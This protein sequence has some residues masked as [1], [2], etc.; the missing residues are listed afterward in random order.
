M[1]GIILQLQG[2]NSE[3]IIAKLKNNLNI[4]ELFI[5]NTDE[6]F[7]LK[8]IRHDGWTIKQI[9]GHL[10]DTQ[11]IWGKRIEQCC[12]NSEVVFESY[13]PEYN[14]VKGDYN[15]TDLNIL[16]QA[17]K[18]KRNEMYHF[19]INDNWNQVGRHPEEGILTV[20]DLAETIALHEIH[21]LEQLEKIK[22][23]MR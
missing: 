22:I 5:E 10:Y 6:S 3:T 14:V 1:G 8:T 19:L 7:L 17:Y 23:N 15:N 9:I 16:F 18:Q 21:H 2:L 11:E 20:K 13:N 12:K 4:I